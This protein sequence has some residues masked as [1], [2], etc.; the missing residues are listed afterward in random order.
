MLVDTTRLKSGIK[1]HCGCKRQYKLHKDK[2]F[3]QEYLGKIKTCTTCWN[4]HPYTNFYFNEVTNIE[5]IKQ[6]IFSSRCIDCHIK[7]ASEYT[8]EHPEMNRES[9]RKTD[10]TPKMQ[11]YHKEAIKKLREDGYFIEYYAKYPERF[12]EYAKN[13]R[14]HDITEA[15]WKSCLKI[16]NYRC[17]YCE[18]TEEE[19][20]RK[21]GERLHK[22]HV[23]HEGYNDIRNAVPGCKSCNS[24]KHQS[25]METWF[26]EQEFFSEERLDFIKW[27]TTEGYKNYIEDKPPYRLTKRQNKDNNKF[28]WELWS[29][30]EM[31]NMVELISIGDK[32]KDLKND[33]EIYSNKIGYFPP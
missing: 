30:D 31:R 33:V 3:P 9:S 6:Y 4:D 24:Q 29:V 25:D 27:W 7:L 10:H 12:K 11:E 18:I 23:D 32:K 26:R 20:K 15:E 21:Y 16:F 17:I 5:G 14:H 28:H 13:H 8:K 19:S 1:T 2:E 22:D